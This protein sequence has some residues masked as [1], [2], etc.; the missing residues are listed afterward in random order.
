[1][2]V[3]LKAETH[4]NDTVNVRLHSVKNIN[5]LQA[6]ERLQQKIMPSNSLCK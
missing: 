6:S 3:G 5:P 1:M 2:S 4:V